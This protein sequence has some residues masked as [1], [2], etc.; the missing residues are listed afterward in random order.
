MTCPTCRDDAAQQSKCVLKA[1]DTLKQHFQMMQ[2]MCAENANKIKLLSQRNEKL[3]IT[4]DLLQQ[5]QLEQRAKLSPKRRKLSPRKLQQEKIPRSAASTEASP[6]LRESQDSL[7]MNIALQLDDEEEEETITETEPAI[8]PYKPWSTRRKLNNRNC[9]N[10]RPANSSSLPTPAA[11]TAATA[12]GT[13]TTADK[14]R[15]G[16]AGKTKLPSAKTKMSL[17]LRSNSP[18]LKQTRLQFDNGKDKDVIESSPNLY[19]ALRQARTRSL[20]Q[21]AA[22]SSASSAGNSTASTGTT[23]RSSNDQPA[24]DMDDDDELFFD[25]CLDP[26]APPQTPKAPPAAAVFPS[27]SGTSNSSSVVLLT[28]ATQDIVF[29]DDSIDEASPA[30]P[31]NT[32]DFMEEAIKQDDKASLTRLQ[33]FEARLIRDQRKAANKV[34]PVETLAPPVVACVKEEPL[35]EQPSDAGNESTKLPA[36]FDLEDDEEEEEIFP[37][38]I[39]VKKEPEQCVTKR[40]KTNCDQ[41]ERFVEFMGSNLNEEKIRIYLENCRHRDAREMDNNTPEGFWNP[42]M[43]SFDEADPRNEVIVDRRFVDR[44]KK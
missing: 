24:F 22:N 1:L 30:A 43:V 16:K 20:L 42:H 26:V 36:D 41:C 13:E 8:S 39:V 29:V 3:H 17:T 9:E 11:A 2:D 7:N 14:Q 27:L 18:R 44:C 34:K 19:L 12:M 38:P 21:R 35:T 37:R 31:L 4:V 5:Q 25:L 33:E 10:L 32:M 6:Q 28:P 40:F 23:L 15:L